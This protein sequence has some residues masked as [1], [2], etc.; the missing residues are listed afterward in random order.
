ML[1]ENAYTSVWTLT[2]SE[3][4]DPRW[5]DHEGQRIRAALT[6]HF[7]REIP[8]AELPPP[9]DPGALRARL[10]QDAPALTALVDRVRTA[11]DVDA[12]CG[13]LIPELGLRDA[14]VDSKRLGVFALSTLLGDVT[15]N[16]PFPQ[17]IWDVRNQGEMSTG[18]S[19]FSENDREADY[20]TDSGFMRHPE[21]IFLLYVVQEARCGGGVSMIRD[22][23]NLINQLATTDRGQA[24]IQALSQTRLPSRIPRAF[25][26]A[27][28][29]SQNGYQYSAVL[30][31]V[32]NT[33]EPLWRWRKDK[34]YKGL[35]K[36][37]EFD[38]PEIRDA[39]DLVSDVL[40]NGADEV[41]SVVPTDGIIIMNN[42]VILHGR[43]GFTDPDRH[44]LRVRL[45]DPA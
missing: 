11:F 19:S 12:V 10:R 41:H 25:R 30:G 31:S 18:H 26:T 28:Y 1:T 8:G 14:D 45:H 6:D 22:G 29:A 35:E 38:T 33:A 40:E 4:T 16:I 5:W 43:T 9:P 3:A 15:A 44:L 17:V 20:H 27:G 39:L 24:A 13:V 23:R 37:P 21:R 32:M 7:G 42:H 36:F 34:L 2:V